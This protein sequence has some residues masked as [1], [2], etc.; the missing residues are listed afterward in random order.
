MEFGIWPF[1]LTVVGANGFTVR[2]GCCLDGRRKV[3]TVRAPSQGASDNLSIQNQDLVCRA[4]RAVGRRSI[5]TPAAPPFD[6][7]RLPP[8]R[9]GSSQPLRPGGAS[10]LSRSSR[11]DDYRLKRLGARARQGVQPRHEF[12]NLGERLGT[13]ML[14]LCDREEAGSAR[15]CRRHSAGSDARPEPCDER[16]DGRAALCVGGRIHRSWNR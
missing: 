6:K 8:T 10:N 1:F 15:R 9:S 2:Q 11:R 14:N 13:V 4:R 12:A 3:A 7:N 5:R 16:S